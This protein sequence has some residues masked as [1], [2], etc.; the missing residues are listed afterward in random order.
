LTKHKYIFKQLED[1][2][3]LSLAYDWDNV[4]LQVGNKHDKTRNVLVTLDVVERVVD[5]AIEKDCNLI[6]A[7]H[8]LLFAPLKELDLSS[9]K[10]QVIHKLIKHNITVYASHTNLDIASGGVNDML[11]DQLQLKETKPLIKTYSEQLFKL[12]VFVPTKYSHQLLEALGDAGAGHIGLYSHC[13][14]LSEGQGTFKPLDGADP[15]VGKI[16]EQHYEEENKLEVIVSEHRIS[17]VLEAMKTYHPYEEVAYDLIKLENNGDNLGLGKIGKLKEPTTLHALCDKIKDRLQVSHVRITGETEKEI[18]KVAVLG[19]SGEKFTQAALHAGADVYITGDMTFH[20]AQ[21]AEEA[22][23][24]VI[25]AG[26]IIEKIMI[27]GITQY[28]SSQFEKI[29]VI[30]SKINTDPFKYY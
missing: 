15:H 14:F 21:D 27:N 9:P 10:G 30:G 11:A 29:N 23:L 7:H 20:A 18:N 5:E 6:I 17:Q 8:P 12:I 1:L 4:G 13:G 3:P 16:N 22:G 26:H 19:G 25:D 24:T 28:L 2:V